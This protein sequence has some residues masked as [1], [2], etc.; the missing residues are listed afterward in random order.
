M[1]FAARQ[2]LYRRIEKQRG[3]K[4]ITFVTS[5]RT[6]MET[7]IAPDCVNLFVE[8]LDEIGP[9]SKISLILHT[10]G[11]HTASAWRIV[12]LID[13]FCD[14]FEVLIPLKAMS[15]GTLISLG[16]D[17]LVMTKQAA[18]GPIDPSLTHALGPQVNTGGMAQ[19][20]PVSVE[21]V[22]GYLDAAKGLGV[23]DPNILAAVLMDLS[24]QLHP[25]VLGEIFRSREQI[26]YLANRLLVRQVSDETKKNAII[27]FLCADSGSH[28][29]TINRREAAAMGLSIEKPSVDLYVLLKNVIDSFTGE[30][31]LLQP[32][33]PQVT[34][35]TNQVAQYQ[36]VRGLVESTKG[37]CYG[38]VSEGTLTRT[39]IAAAPIAQEAVTDQRTFEGWKRLP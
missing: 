23:Q 13:T 2:K 8:L 25:L 16:A 3:S 26:R 36:E 27:D 31:K 34:L 1:N 10:N 37:G 38:Y 22:R 18:L 35:G 6:G 12:N 20:V 32:Y 7:Q 4:V 30:L 29:Y 39:V 17:R 19:R 21:A 24:K 14:E 28:D 9:T 15:A 5:D 11:G 33:S